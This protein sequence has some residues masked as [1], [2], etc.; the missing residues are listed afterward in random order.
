MQLIDSNA[1][2]QDDVGDEENQQQ[3][4]QA[5]HKIKLI[6]SSESVKI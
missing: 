5:M 2:M 1:N 4:G 3:F 6:D